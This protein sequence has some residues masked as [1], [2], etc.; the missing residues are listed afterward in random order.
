MR[1]L[2]AFASVFKISVGDVSISVDPEA[3]TAD[4]GNL[5]YDLSDLFTRVGATARGRVPQRG[6]GAVGNWLGVATAESLA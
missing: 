2:R 4:S 3:G 1:A 6:V 5:E